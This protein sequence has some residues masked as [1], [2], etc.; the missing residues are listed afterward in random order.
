MIRSFGD[1]T[2]CIAESAFVSEAAYVIGDVIIGEDSGI[3]PGAVIRGDFASIKIGRNTM[4]E[5][6]CVIHTG[7]PV[8]IGDRVTIGHNVVM[9]GLKIGNY[10]LIGNNATILDKSVIGN[11]CIIAAGCLV[12]PGMKIPDN[13]M[14]MG[15]P[16]VIKP[17]SLALKKKLEGSGQAYARLL[18]QYK[19]QP[20]L[21]S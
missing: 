17:L 10:S 2:P 7:E 12:S 5:D 13:S 6:N 11:F 14:V 15:L 20:E 16:G 4:V 1:K 3:F 19:Q 9:H 21:K 8:D 18:K